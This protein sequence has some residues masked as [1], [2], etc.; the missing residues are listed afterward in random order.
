MAAECRGFDLRPRYSKGV[1]KM[2]SDA[3]LL[4]AQHNYKDMSGF[5]LLLNLVQTMRWILSGMSGRE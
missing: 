4:S 2:V 1:I 3:S 5:S